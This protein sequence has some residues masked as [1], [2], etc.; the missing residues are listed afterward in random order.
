MS[1]PLYLRE[2][3]RELRQHR[4]MTLDQLIRCLSL[5]KTTIYW[6]RD[7]AQPPASSEE[8]ELSRRSYC[9]RRRNKIG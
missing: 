9:E 3:A 7:L 4:Q 2:R 1:H 5:P 6:I 8:Q